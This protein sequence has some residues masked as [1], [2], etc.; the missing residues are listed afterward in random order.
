MK[1]LP[2]QARIPGNEA[3]DKLAKEDIL[4]GEVLMPDT[5]NE[6]SK[7]ANIIQK[8]TMNDQLLLCNRATSRI[9]NH[10]MTSTKSNLGIY[11][12]LIRTFWYRKLVIWDVLMVEIPIAKTLE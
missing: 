10:S 6:I 7:I 4:D 2:D 8:I 9:S 1:W 11:H 5:P 12:D 3:V